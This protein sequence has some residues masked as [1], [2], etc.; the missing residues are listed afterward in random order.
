MFLIDNNENKITFFSQDNSIVIEFKKEKVNR[1]FSF[2]KNDSEDRYLYTMKF[3]NNLGTTIKE[4]QLSDAE[5]YMLLDN[6][7]SFIS[8]NLESIFLSLSCKDS[9][10]INYILS[11]ETIIPDTQITIENMF[12]YKKNVFK[13]SEVSADNLT[14]IITFEISNTIAE[15]VDCVYN[16]CIKDRNDISSDENITCDN[17]GTLIKPN[18]LL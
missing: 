18:F 10:G 1:T 4:I 7:Y 15:F 3:M 16:I 12:E 17:I 2:A 14:T 6:V 11:I 9:T 13:L 8:L 5:M